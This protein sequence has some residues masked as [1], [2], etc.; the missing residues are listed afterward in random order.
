MRY[1]RGPARG[2]SDLT[3]VVKKRQIRLA[4]PIAAASV[5]AAP[6]DRAQYIRDVALDVLL[7]SASTDANAVENGRVRKSTGW[8]HFSRQLASCMQS[9]LGSLQLCAS[10]MAFILVAFEATHPRSL[11]TTA[12]HFSML[13]V[14]TEVRSRRAHRLS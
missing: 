11:V 6:S 9:R 13:H 7:C 1:G 14:L 12:A 8:P 2:G 10:L 3:K 5:H 4:T